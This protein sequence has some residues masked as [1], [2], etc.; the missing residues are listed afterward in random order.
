VK[1]IKVGDALKMNSKE[2]V[3][4]EKA[5]EEAYRPLDSPRHAFVEDSI[6]MQP[7]REIVLK[8]KGHFE[9]VRED[10]DSNTDVSFGYII[11]R[12]QY[13]LIIRISMVGP[14]A[15]VMRSF[16]DSSCELIERRNNAHH[17]QQDLGEEFV[18]DLLESE[19]LKILGK[20]VLSQVTSLSNV[21]EPEKE[22]SI[23]QALFV[24]DED[25]PWEWV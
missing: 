25:F 10:T 8:L 5:I 11:P 13:F 20:K 22:V 1:R 19:G 18:F 7:F 2:I 14:F 16:L 21:T 9:K 23:F 15:L 12:S 4:I 17:G 6:Q 24:D 3:E